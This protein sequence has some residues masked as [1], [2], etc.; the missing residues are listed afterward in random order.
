MRN[1]YLNEGPPSNIYPNKEEWQHLGE[2]GNYTPLTSTLLKESEISR[3]TTPNFD[4]GSNI[5][6]GNI[7]HQ[8]PQQKYNTKT[9]KLSVDNSPRSLNLLS[10]QLG[11]I[12]IKPLNPQIRNENEHPNMIP[13][14]Q[15]T[16]LYPNM[17]DT[18]EHQNMSKDT[19]Y[20]LFPNLK[21]DNDGNKNFLLAPLETKNLDSNLNFNN[22]FVDLN[23]HQGSPTKTTPLNPQILNPSQ[24][25]F[26]S[27][28][29]I[30]NPISNTTAPNPI[31]K[32]PN[33]GRRESN[34]VP[35]VK[36]GRAHV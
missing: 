34:P 31:I 13:I 23:T 19:T 16:T 24:S 18:G 33:M 35:S 21:M 17:Y 30:L 8:P 7:T 2:L 1:I 29:L 28:E 3:E 15:K 6:E 10:D 9:G 11:T 27:P 12:P 22:H 4:N 14:N 32:S 20:D 26:N 25:L 36:I 5:M